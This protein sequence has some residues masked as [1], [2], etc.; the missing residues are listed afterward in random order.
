LSELIDRAT[1][2]IFIPITVGGGVRSIDDAQSILRSGADKVAINTGAVHNPRLITE[3]AN[4]YG[5]QCM[6][7]SIE[8]KKIASDRWEVLTDN[9]REK[10]G[11]EVL[12]W[13]KLGEQAGAGEILITSVDKEGTRTGFDL[14]LLTAVASNVNIPIIA[15]GGMGKP[16]DAI[17]AAD[18]GNIDA[19]AMADIIHYKRSS[20]S[21]IRKVAT[22]AGIKVRVDEAI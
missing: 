2:N 6:V 15:S 11:L 3:V 9:G 14:D 16:E 22:N 4:R 12:Q 19:I 1:K 8:A 21:E 17:S 7:L 18:I 13:A 5:T 10:T 20:F